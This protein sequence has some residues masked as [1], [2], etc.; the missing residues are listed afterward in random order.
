[1]SSDTTVREATRNKRVAFRTFGCKL[2]L[3]E[4]AGIGQ[5]A[6]ARGFQLQ[7]DHAQDPADILV[8]NTCSVTMRADQEARQYIRKVHRK[9]P[10]TR[11]V[12]TGCYAQRAP[13][14]LATLPGVAMVVGH[15]EKDQLGSLLNSLPDPGVPAEVRV[16]PIDQK[17][18]PTLRAHGH[19]GRTRA[20]L[21]VQDGCDA[22]CTYCIIPKTRGRS[23]SLNFEEAVEEG[24]RLIVDA[25]FR[26]IVLTGTHL[27]HFGIDNDRRRRLSELVEA[28][29]DLRAPHGFRIRLSSVEP[30]EIDQKL[31]DM[32]ETRPELAA[33][34]HLP[35]Q[36]GSDAVLRRMRRAYRTGNYR[37]QVERVSSSVSP[38]AL[39]ADLIVGF[40][41]E[42]EA[43]FR[44]TLQFLAELP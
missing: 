6:E 36:S 25:G 7:E 31:I 27:G 13:E 12:V 15:A 18:M 28:L 24:R 9:H 3:Y 43:D 11:I 37:K 20:F 30:Q 29:I 42:T 44:R 21:R 40:P 38:L 17:N 16:A 8:V 32:F 26:E 2:N 1:M 33:H 10:E 19:Q 41:G 34:L 22:A 39:G 23:H 5:Q 4:S 14:E 35:L